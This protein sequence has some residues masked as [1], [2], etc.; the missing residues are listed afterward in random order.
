MVSWWMSYG[1][2]WSSAMSSRW[3]TTSL[4]LYVASSLM[5]AIMP[6]ASSHRHGLL[7]IN[8]CSRVLMNSC[9]F[10]VLPSWAAMLDF[11]GLC[12]LSFIILSLF[13]C[14]IHPHTHTHTTVLRLCGICPGQPG[15][16]GTHRGHQS[17]LSASS[18]YYDPWHPPY[19]IHVLC[20]ETSL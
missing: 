16:A 3:K 2:R 13:F 17:S 6:I 9:S 10:C 1:T 20:M 19:S 15:W 18:I 4:L 14:C 12:V 5:C 7:H 8:Q 11:L